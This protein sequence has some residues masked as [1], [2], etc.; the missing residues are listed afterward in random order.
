[1]APYVESFF[2]AQTPDFIDNKK[3]RRVLKKITQTA[4]MAIYGLATVNL[5]HILAALLYKSSGRP[6]VEID[7]RRRA[8]LA[9]TSDSR[10]LG[11]FCHH[12]LQGSQVDLLLREDDDRVD[13]FLKLAQEKGFLQV[14]GMSSILSQ[15]AKPQCR[16]VDSHLREGGE[17]FHQV[18]LAN[19]FLVMANAIEPLKTLTNSFR[20]S[21]LDPGLVSATAYG[22]ASLESMQQKFLEERKA[23]SG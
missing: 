7:F 8:Y 22:P 9:A 3:S 5:D 21:F 16:F 12:G 20:P 2:G 19:P 17:A 15:K 14:S 23:L 11:I 4:M 18:R 1:M 6:F 13:G 10:V